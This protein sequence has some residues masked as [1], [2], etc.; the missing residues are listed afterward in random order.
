VLGL[1]AAMPLS[2]LRLA[3]LV[4][5]HRIASIRGATVVAVVWTL[6]ALFGVQAQPGEPVAS[7]GAASVGY[8]LVRQVRA[9]I[10][11][12]QTFAQAAASDPFGAMP[13]ADLL[14]G[15]RGKDVGVRR[16]LRP[17]GGRRLGRVGRDRRHA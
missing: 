4:D 5:R 13:A 9:G 10:R 12:Q 15:L 14:T 7:E 17:R 16:E 3:R 1:L 8:A 11:D 2:V 6:C